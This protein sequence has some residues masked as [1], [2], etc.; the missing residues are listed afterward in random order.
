MA[1]DSFSA[2]EL[3]KTEILTLPVQ[4]APPFSQGSTHVYRP[5]VVQAN[6]L[7]FYK[8]TVSQGESS[9]GVGLGLAS[10]AQGIVP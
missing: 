3:I 4:L 7:G 10:S 2:W 1:V 8:G 9:V 5:H 6:M